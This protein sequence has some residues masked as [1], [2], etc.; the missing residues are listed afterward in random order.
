MNHVGFGYLPIR[1]TSNRVASFALVLGLIA[2]QS[3]LSFMY[4]KPATLSRLGDASQSPLLDIEMGSTNATRG[5]GALDD[6]SRAAFRAADNVADFTV[7]TK[8]LPGSA[9]NYAKFADD[10]DPHAA[11]QEAL[12]S[13]NAMFLPNQLPG[14]FRVV[15]DLGYPVGSRG[16]TALRIIVGNDGTVWNAFPVK[17]L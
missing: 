15:T 2:V 4:D 5:I 9:G 7:P 1:T 10:V 14:S 13:E 16:Q 3:S 17:S 6:A 8:H 11:I 12:R